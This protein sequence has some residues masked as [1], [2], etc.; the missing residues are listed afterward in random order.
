MKTTAGRHYGHAGPAF[1]EALL[2]D[3]RDFAAEVGTLFAAK[4][5]LRMV[6][7]LFALTYQ[8]AFSFDASALRKP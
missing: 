7:L 3:G 6:A 4:P 1:V 2:R 5:L 8:S